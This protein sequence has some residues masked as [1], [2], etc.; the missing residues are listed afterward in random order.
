MII[1]GYVVS[2]VFFLME[3]AALAA[4]G[5][6]GFHIG[7]TLLTRIILGIGSPLITAIIWGMFA[8]AKPI[9]RVSVL[10]SILIQLAIFGTAIIALYFAGQRKLAGV[11][12]IVVLVEMVLTYV[13]KIAI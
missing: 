2:L 5:Y 6:W 3:L 11:Y 1:I 7:N 12:S 13:F 9:I 10:V 8:S 4:F